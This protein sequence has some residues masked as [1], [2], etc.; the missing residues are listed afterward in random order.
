MLDMDEVT[1]A[2]TSPITD[3][4]ESPKGETE[5][6]GEMSSHAN[7]MA[8]VLKNQGRLEAKLDMLIDM[9]SEEE[10]EEVVDDGYLTLPMGSQAGSGGG[11]TYDMTGATYEGL[12]LPVTYG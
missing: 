4:G 8:E 9:E 10:P 12:A 3:S 2:L 11:N 7:M 5:Y 6:A 1:E